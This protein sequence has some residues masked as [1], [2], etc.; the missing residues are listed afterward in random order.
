MLFADPLRLAM[1]LADADGLEALTIRKLATDLGVTPM[2]LYWH[3]RSK[4]E[5]LGGLVERV[6][7]EIDTNVEPIDV[8]QS[9]QRL[10]PRYVNNRQQALWLIPASLN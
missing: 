1:Q 4:E 2:A 6:W 5:L 7:S 9:F 3:F 8:K 10:S